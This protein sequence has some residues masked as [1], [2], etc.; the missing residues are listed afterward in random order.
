MTV[1]EETHID[2]LKGEVLLIDKPLEWS[3]FDL[4]KKIRNL[5]RRKLEVKKIKV[6]HAGTLDPLASGLMIICT[7]KATKKIESFQGQ[8]KEYIADLKLGESTPSFDLETEVDKTYP[9]DHIGLD[10]IE[11]TLEQFRGEIMQVPPLFSAKRLGGKRAYEFARK[12]EDIKLNPVPVT[13][14]ELEILEFMGAEKKS[15]R[16]TGFEHSPNRGSDSGL[17]L[18]L[19]VRCSKGTYIRS[20]ASDI[21][22]ALESGAYLAGLR[23]TAIGDYRVDDAMSLKKFE[24]K[25]NIV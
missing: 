19:R 4:V 18:R 24:E 25:L 1:R 17:Y 15:E 20:L 16:D 14:H 10:F 8:P 13:I 3:S 6:G 12:G 11:K 7:G 5:L 23:R 2:Y 22:K 21:G 9:T